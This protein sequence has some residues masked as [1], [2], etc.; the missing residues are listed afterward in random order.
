MKKIFSML[1]FCLIAAGCN[2]S[3]FQLPDASEQMPQNIFFNNKVDVLMM[4]DNSSSMLPRQQKLA[5]QIPSMI[6]SL[7]AQGMDY[8]IAIVT[9]DVR[10]GG[11]GGKFIGSPAVLSNG[12]ANLVSVLQNR[13]LQ[14][15]VPG[16]DL[17]SGLKSIQLALQGDVNGGSPVFVRDDAM[18]AILVLSDEDDFSSGSS[19]SYS[20]FIETVK[21]P[22]PSGNRSWIMNYIG[23]LPSD[24]LCK[25]AGQYADPGARYL[26]LVDISGGVTASICNSS[27]G[28]AV[29]NV[30]TRIN[31][32]LSDYYFERQP[33]PETI[34]VTRNGVSVPNSTTDG[35]S[36]QLDPKSNKYFIRFSG[37]YLPV[38]T[39]KIIVNYSPTSAT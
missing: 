3:G 17:E 27:L 4:I 22:F 24:E 15:E 21:K 16:A 29:T 18:L 39:D 31:Q 8:R 1:T 6:S 2:N 30:R 12:T 26:D 5:A 23:V 32:F 9:S 35:W 14:G 19:S 7:N 25:T 37:S 20:N 36:L 33:K 11:N 38:P 10:T 13:V 34:S 28:N